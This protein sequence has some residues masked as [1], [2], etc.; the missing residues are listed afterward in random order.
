MAGRVEKVGL[1]K[2]WLRNVGLTFERVVFLV[3]ICESQLPRIDVVEEL[4]VA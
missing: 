1:G 4:V 2:V 3:V